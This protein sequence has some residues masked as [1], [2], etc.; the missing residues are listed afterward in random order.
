MRVVGTNVFG[1]FA[2][3]QAFYPLLKVPLSAF[4][5]DTDVICSRAAPLARQRMLDGPPVWPMLRTTDGVTRL[6]ASQEVPAPE[7]LLLASK[8]L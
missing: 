5:A 4:F 7:M 3:I 6:H 2:T 1:A 8:P